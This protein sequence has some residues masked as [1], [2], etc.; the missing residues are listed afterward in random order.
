MTIPKIENSGVISIFIEPKNQAGS[1]DKDTILKIVKIVACILAAMIL[2]V[3]LWN[4][5]KISAAIYKFATPP[6]VKAKDPF[7]QFDKILANKES[8]KSPKLNPPVTLL[9]TAPIENK[10]DLDVS[11]NTPLECPI[12]QDESKDVTHPQA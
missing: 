11:L 6:V 12:D 1:P 3:E 5:I 8:P 4:L 2:I 7:A 10:L 9:L